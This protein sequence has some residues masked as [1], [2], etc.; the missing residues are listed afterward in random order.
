MK[1]NNDDYK[2]LG[3]LVYEVSRLL[4]RNYDQRVQH[5]GLTQAQWRALAHIL[6]NEGL[7]QITLAERLEIKPITI[8]RLL[9]RMQAAGWVERKADP[10]DRRATRLYISQSAKPLLETLGQFAYET[11]EQA[12]SGLDEEERGQLFSLLAKMKDNLNEPGS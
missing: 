1:S 2:N 7:N 9:D 4:R 8:S 11:R 10:D 3:F 6:H 5:L 12:M